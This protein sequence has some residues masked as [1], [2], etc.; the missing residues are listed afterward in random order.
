MAARVLFSPWRFQD[1]DVSLSPKGP[2]SV[3]GEIRIDEV[4]FLSRNPSARGRVVVFGD[5]FAE[6]MVQFF[7][8]HFNEVHRY[9]GGTLDGS[10]IASHRP[11][12][13]LLEVAERY[14]DALLKPPVELTRA[15]LM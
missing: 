1:E 7:A 13:V 10:I 2:L 9:I 15:C 4:H 3:E 6:R 8:P 5:S 12:L 11:Q 14:L